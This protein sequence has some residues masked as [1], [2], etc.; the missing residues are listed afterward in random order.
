MFGT[1]VGMSHTTKVRFQSDFSSSDKV[2]NMLQRVELIFHI[3]HYFVDGME[4][5][6]ISLHQQFCKVLLSNLIQNFYLDLT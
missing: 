1:I 4:W 6:V 5:Y 3:G 2:P